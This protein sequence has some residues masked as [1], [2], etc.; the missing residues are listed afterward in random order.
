MPVTAW[1]GVAW[2]S[3]AL[4]GGPA[5]GSSAELCL[6][7]HADVSVAP[8][9]KLKD[10]DASAHRR[11]D[12]LACHP[13]AG[14]Q[15]HPKGLRAVD[16]A[17]CHERPAR[18]LA[19]SPHGQAVLARHRGELRRACGACHGR[20]HDIRAPADSRSKVA[21]PKMASTCGGCHGAVA[22]VFGASVHGKA[23]SHGIRAAPT[24][25]DCH[26]SHSIRPPREAGGPLSPGKRAGTCEDCHQSTRLATRFGLPKDRVQ[27]FEESFHGLAGRGGDVKVADCASCHGWHDV[28]P[29]TDERSRIHPQNLASTCGQCH[30]DAGRRWTAGSV[31]VHQTLGRDGGGSPIARFVRLLYLIAIPLTALGMV[32]HNGLDLARKARAP[33]RWRHREGEVPLSPSERWQHAANAVAFV[34]LAYSGF[35]LQLPDAWWAAPLRAIGGEEARRDAHRAAAAL[36]LVTGAVHAAYLA[37][38]KGRARL[39]A[40]LP[41]RR[42]LRD[43]LELAAYNAGLRDKPPALL[44][45]SYIEKFEYWALVWGSFVMTATGGLLLFH[46]AALA[47][48]PLWTVEV[49]RTAHYL[50]AV[51]ACLA[52]LL[53]HGYWVALDP[54]VYPMDWAWLRGEARHPGTKEK[55]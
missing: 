51:L 53:W 3:V 42:D 12:C 29:S 1:L 47:W 23:A 45:F 43:P 17:R 46:N 44:Q 49:A 19:A 25:S 26:G 54:E 8:D 14:E 40:M 35:A 4:A 2:A 37:T 30:P 9:P 36:F 41:A 11:L 39:R 50:E 7:C 24:C 33:R 22:A 15:P 18:E 48:L 55:P 28:L 13:Q 52:I 38:R 32:L 27:T 6:G 21:G 34:L 16:C 5:P 10:L 20:V 31:K